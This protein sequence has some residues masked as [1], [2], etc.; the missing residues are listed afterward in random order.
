M[1]TLSYIPTEEGFIFTHNRDERNDRPTSD[2]FRIRDYGDASIYY[3][4]D[5]EAHG[6]WIAFSDQGCTACLLNGGEKPY[7]RRSSYRHSRGLVVLGFFDYPNAESFF[8][9]YNFEDLEPFTLIIKDG[10]GLFKVVHDEDKTRLEELNPQQKGIWSSTSLYTHEARQK[11]ELW[12]EK[13]LSTT[14]EISA[15]AIKDFHSTAGDGDQENDLVMSRWGL[16]QTLSITQIE[17]A[18]KQA[19]LYYRDLLRQTQDHRQ[20]L[21]GDS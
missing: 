16:L 20:L 18:G 19:S 7:E 11:R 6:S 10:Q 1:C 12:F 15:K 5:L 9:G 3:P 14:R 13:W 2:K 21:L 8:R 4:E 17:V